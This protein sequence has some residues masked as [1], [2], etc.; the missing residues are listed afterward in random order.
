MA[1]DRPYGK[2]RF[3]VEIDG[4][5]VAHCQAVTGLSAEVGS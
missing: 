5:T 4:L 3:K 1:A 2:F